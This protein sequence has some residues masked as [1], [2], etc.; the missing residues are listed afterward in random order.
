V[1]QMQ[2]VA[3]IPAYE[4]EERFLDQ[5]PELRQAG[6]DCVVVT[7]GADGQHATAD[8]LRV[9]RAKTTNPHTAI[10]ERKVSDIVYISC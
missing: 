3:L 9:A 7:V 4:P 8:A 2:K 10:K 6:F 5:L 1:I